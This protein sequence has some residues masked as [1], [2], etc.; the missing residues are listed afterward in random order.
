M[1]RNEMNACR[2]MKSRV[3]VM[4]MIVRKKFFP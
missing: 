2:L 1:E 4:V 3:A